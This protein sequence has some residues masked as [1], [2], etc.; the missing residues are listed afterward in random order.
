M[1]S[2]NLLYKT[3]SLLILAACCGAATAGTLTVYLSPPSAQS[4]TV[5]GVANETFDQLS[6]AYALLL[7]LRRPGLALIRA[8]QAIPWRLQHPACLAGH[9]QYSHLANHYFSVGNST[10]SISPV[11]SDS[12]PTRRVFWVLVVRRRPIQTGSIC[13][14]GSTLFA[15]FSTQDLLTF[16]NNGV[17][18]V[19]AGSGATYQTSA[20][21]GNPNIASGNRDARSPL[22]MS[23]S[24]S[25]GATIDKLAFYN[26]SST[27]SAFES[28]NHSG[29]FS[30]NSVTIPTTFVLVE[31]LNSRRRRR[32]R[33]FSRWRGRNTS[34]QT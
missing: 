26:T 11:L 29:H 30:G 22:F 24:R 7:I 16:L 18:T 25:P 3:T 17:G 13:Y 31:T 2:R 19:T 21:F 20:Y 12:E 4:S 34:A 10:N 33:A 23:V 28:D 27:G 1:P 32:R 8:A 6:T 9:G 15:T 14:Q 5:A